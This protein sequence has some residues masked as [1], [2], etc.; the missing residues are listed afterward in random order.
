MSEAT[1][2]E[3]VNHTLA[4]AMREDERVIVLGE[5]VAEG[6]PYLVTAGLAE[7]FGRARVR[8]TP[9][10]EGAVCGVAVGAAQAGLKPVVEIMFIDFIT[11][12]LDQ[13]VNQAAKAHFMSGGQ[14]TVPLVLRTQGGSGQRNGAQHSQSLEAWLTHVPGLKV[15]MP[16]GAADATGLL[17][18]AIADPNPVVFVEN[19]S[20]YFRKEPVPDP[21]E[22]IPLGRARTL[23]AG[24]DV[25]IVALSR[26]VG[27]AIEAAERLS[28][29]HGVEAEVIDPR[30]LVPL[31]L[32]TLAE[33]VRRTGRAII[34][35]E[36]VAAGGFGA[37]L[38]AQLQAA[39]FDYLEAPIQRVGAPYTP[40]PVSPPLEDAYRPASGEIVRAAKI[41]MEW[42]QYDAEPWEKGALSRPPK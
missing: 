5:D 31:D 39:A 12:A 36:A 4:H 15:V 32:D 10:S 35:H 34:A 22:P 16:S 13:L 25:T 14:L 8:N 6:G 28:G 33:S 37:E 19:K 9:I 18:S 3:A 41:A 29:E 24:R 23:R 17:M 20:L 27:D 11:L 40:V 1:F 7:E 21:P 42:G 38:A 30:T 2:V 26:L